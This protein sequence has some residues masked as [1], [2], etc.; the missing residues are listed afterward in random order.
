[1]TERRY[2]PNAGFSD[3]KLQYIMKSHS[4]FQDSVLLRDIV[5]QRLKNKRITLI[6]FLYLH[7]CY[8]T[9]QLHSHATNRVKGVVH[10]KM[11]THSLSSHHYVDGEVGDV[12]ESAKHLWSFRGKQSCKSK[13]EE[14]KDEHILTREINK[15]VEW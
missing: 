13:A 12:W 3:R 2:N 11:K 8:K 14:V 5:F 4:Q 7:S 15:H 10:Q 9:T 1:M 6:V